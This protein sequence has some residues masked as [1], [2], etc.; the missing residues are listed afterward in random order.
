LK[1]KISDLIRLSKIKLSLIISFGG[2]FLIALISVIHSYVLPMIGIDTYP[3]LK[4]E[5][6]F[7]K[8][9]LNF[10][11]SQYQALNY[12]L[13]SL[14]RINNDLRL[15]VNLEPF[16]S[17]EQM[18]G[19]GGGYFDNEID[20]LS[21]ESRLQLQQVFAFMDE[22]TR[23]VE[24]EKQQY[25]EISSKFIDNKKLFEAMP[26]I[27]PCEGTLSYHGFGPRL[28]PILNIR[29]MHEGIDIITDKGTPVYATGK[30]V[31]D[32]VG[33]NGG[34]GLAVEIDHGFGYKSIY[35]H[36][37]KVDVRQ[38]QKVNRGDL[39]AKTGNTGL[40]SGP[41]LHYEVHHNGIKQNPVEFF[42]D[43]LNF[44]EIKNDN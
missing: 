35:A 8:Q 7:L 40:S 19:V 6:E 32:F 27:R 41:H 21:E 39:I 23:K 34:L 43:D 26:A 20:F 28:H 29:R 1:Y 13:D 12:E 3:A 18:I 36:L 33:V 11:L 44:F 16:S 22:V 38:G 42:F 17:E 4:R 15:A 37:S 14:L 25:F 9:R 10:V 31:V 2:L 5:N 24:F 30:G